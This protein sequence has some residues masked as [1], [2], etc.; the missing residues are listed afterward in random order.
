MSIPNEIWFGRKESTNEKREDHK[1][2]TGERVDV[3]VPGG[4]TV[5]GEE[6]VGDEELGC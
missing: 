3:E 1:D 5:G 6:E 4:D 2:A